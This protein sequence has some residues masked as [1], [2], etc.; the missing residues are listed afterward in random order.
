M[1]QKR[2]HRSSMQD[3]RGG[4]PPRTLA[5]AGTGTTREP[6]I[7]NA[8]R[9]GVTSLALIGEL[10]R[11]NENAV[12]VVPRKPVHVKRR[13]RSLF[14]RSRSK[15]CMAQGRFEWAATRKMLDQRNRQM[16]T[17][18]CG[19]HPDQLADT[20]GFVARQ[21]LCLA[22]FVHHVKMVAIPDHVVASAGTTS[23]E[24][25]FRFAKTRKQRVLEALAESVRAGQAMQNVL[26]VIRHQ[27]SKG[28]VQAVLRH[29]E[30]LIGYDAKKGVVAEELFEALISILRVTSFDEGD[31]KTMTAI[32]NGGDDFFS[33]TFQ[34]AALHRLRFCEKKYL[35]N[36]HFLSEFLEKG[37]HEHSQKIEFASGLK[38]V[39]RG[40][41]RA[42]TLIEHSADPS[43]LKKL[44][45]AV[46]DLKELFLQVPAAVFVRQET[47]MSVK[48]SLHLL[49]RVRT[50]LGEEFRS[51]F[52]EIFE[53]VTGMKQA[54]DVLVNLFDPS[55][56]LF[57]PN[58]H[59]MQRFDDSFSRIKQVR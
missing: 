33:E 7:R 12:G 6:L 35:V 13:A 10:G 23:W 25:F 58:H 36:Q 19:L 43:C 2:Y 50:V 21:Q 31:R 57:L 40:C 47:R 54:A 42:A 14:A 48:K 44:K 51:P 1:N 26:G 34:E 5:C 29:A 22:E 32:L 59:G 37:V 56:V 16:V 38:N 49:Q 52:S 55:A 45:N 4:Q 17:F 11:V 53:K 27:G 20:Y 39:L 41:R 30:N 9:P 46:P 15:Q 28:R 18:L 24:T 8:P 3:T